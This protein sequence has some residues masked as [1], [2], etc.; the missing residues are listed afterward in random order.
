MLK[1]YTRILYL[2]DFSTAKFAAAILVLK[3]AI[4]KGFPLKKRMV[5][6]IAPQ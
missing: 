4:I 3:S 1:I 2:V 6:P 5:K